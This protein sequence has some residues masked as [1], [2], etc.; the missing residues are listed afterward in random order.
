VVLLFVGLSN[1]FESEGFDRQTLELPT[2]QRELIEAVLN[3]NPNTILVVNSGSTVLLHDWAERARAVVSTWYYGQE[4]GNAIADILL[5][6]VNPSG[7]LPFTWI[8]RWEDHSSFGRYPGS[9]GR[10]DYTEGVFLGYRWADQQAIAPKFPFGH[11]LNYSQFNLSFPTL[12][13]DSSSAENPS[14]TIET[15]IENT[16]SVRGAEVVQLYVQDEVSSVPRPIRELKGFKK[17]WLNPGESR[18]VRFELDHSAFAFFDSASHAW[19]VEPGKFRL[20]LGTSSRDLP[21]Q[22]DLLL[23]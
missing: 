23:N 9:A 7:K 13:I 5:G 8:K 19:I 11:G 17:V 2:N 22:L 14:V 18:L 20:W 15:I 10:V 3:A 16:S 6:H 21:I 12:Q 4:G 1:F